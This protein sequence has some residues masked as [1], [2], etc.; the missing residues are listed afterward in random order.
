MAMN[1]ATDRVN[2]IAASDMPRAIA[3]IGEAVWWITIV[4]DT[5]RHD[6]RTPYDQTATLTSPDPT[7]TIKGLRSVRNRI[8]HRVDL[9]DFIQPVATRDWSADGR[10]TA[11]AWKP[12]PPPE[13]GDRT[14]RQYRHELEL[15]QAYESA[16]AGQNIWQPFMRAT[17]F[18]GQVFRVVRGEI[19][20]G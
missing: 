8:G 17:G 7:D 19:G 11:G 16:L 4:N 10:I 6:H 14:D 13:Q 18:F 5:L 3:A 15:H 1:D 12:A 9:I 20:A 2:K